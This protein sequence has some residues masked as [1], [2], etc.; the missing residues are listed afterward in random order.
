[1][2]ECVCKGPSV[3]QTY[4]SVKWWADCRSRGF[5]SLLIHHPHTLPQSRKLQ[6]LFLSRAGSRPH[7]SHMSRPLYRRRDVHISGKLKSL[8]FGFKG[9]VV[10]GNSALPETRNEDGIHRSEPSTAELLAARTHNT[11]SPKSSRGHPPQ[12]YYHSIIL[13]QE[14]ENI[15]LIKAAL[16][17]WLTPSCASMIPIIKEDETGRWVGSLDMLAMCA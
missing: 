1:M 4:L 2:R 6:A 16:H 11:P 13:I 15:S 12:I 17:T 5:L 14:E 10:T 9:K 3:K 7:P 8:W